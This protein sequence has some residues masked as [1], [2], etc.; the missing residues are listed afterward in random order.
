[1][2]IDFGE[3]TKGEEEEEEISIVFSLGPTNGSNQ[4]GLGANKARRGGRR[5]G[6]G[7][8]EGR[9]RA[10]VRNLKYKKKTVLYTS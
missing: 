4:E 6:G 1:M 2:Q 9:K 7:V 3:K 5:R 8:G 10:R